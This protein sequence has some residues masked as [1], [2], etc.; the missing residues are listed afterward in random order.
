MAAA[1]ALATVGL[2]GPA[3]AQ[4]PQAAS[5]FVQQA[6]QE[7][8]AVVNGPASREAK[9]QQLRQIVD[10]VV[11]VDEVAR[12]CLGRYWRTATPDQQK[13]YL[14][15][16]HQVLLKNITG[17]LG[18]YQ[19]VTFT[20]GRATQ[21]AN[22]VAVATVVARP[23]TPPT[24]VEWWVSGGASP[25]IVDVVAEGTSMRLTQRNDYDSYLSHN[26]N[27]VGALLEAMRR[28]LAQAG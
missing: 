9:Q 27:N 21:R 12:F 5:A 22:A 3:R 4:T 11:D 16:F 23:G 19:G 17:K 10:R 14:E 18:D 28:Q 15:L 25:R 24:N 2:A 20:V 8:V 13:Q 1:A 26:G 6:G 7:L